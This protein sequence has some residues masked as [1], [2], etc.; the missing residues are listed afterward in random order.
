MVEGNDVVVVNKGDEGIMTIETYNKQHIQNM[1]EMQDYIDSFKK[2]DRKQAQ[3]EARES[4]IRS[5]VLNKNGTVKK[6]ICN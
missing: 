2:M 3:K 4:L 5:G 1:K 6:K